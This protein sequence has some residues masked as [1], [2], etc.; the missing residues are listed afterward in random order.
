MNVVV[1]KFLRRRKG[2]N[3]GKCTNTFVYVSFRKKKSRKTGVLR[4]QFLVMSL[5]FTLTTCC[6]LRIIRHI[7]KFNSAY[8]MHVIGS[9]QCFKSWKT[10]EEFPYLRDW[11]FN[12]TVLRPVIFNFTA[13]CL[14]VTQLP[15]FFTF[16]RT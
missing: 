4:G 9:L 3:S 15:S 8:F 11:C 7:Y 14:A 2:L 6:C 12:F 1:V 13:Y 16:G 10:E 5:N